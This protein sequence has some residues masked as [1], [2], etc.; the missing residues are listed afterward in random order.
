MIRKQVY[1]TAELAERLGREAKR[2]RRTEAEVF[3]QALAARLNATEPSSSDPRKT[4]SGSS[5]ALGRRRKQIFPSAS[6]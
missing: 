3:R 5:S 6:M 4:L 1:L 2:Q